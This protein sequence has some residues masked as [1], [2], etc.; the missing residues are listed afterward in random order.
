MRKASRRKV[1]DFSQKLQT[2]FISN[3]ST[4]VIACA[5]KLIP[6]SPAV[7]ETIHGGISNHTTVTPTSL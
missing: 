4:F 6:K 2:A 5:V 3:S 7:N 1:D